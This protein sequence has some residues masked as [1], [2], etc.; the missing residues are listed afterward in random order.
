MTK[1]NKVT[2]N[3]SV[4][5]VDKFPRINTT[6]KYLIL[7]KYQN[8]FHKYYEE[9]LKEHMP[10]MLLKK[11]L[12]YNTSKKLHEALLSS[13]Y[14]DIEPKYIKVK[15]ALI[16]GDDTHF[17]N[18]SGWNDYFNYI[19]SDK[20]FPIFKGMP[21]RNRSHGGASPTDLPA[22]FIL[23]LIKKNI[24]LAPLYH[25]GLIYTNSYSL[26]KSVKTIFS[27]DDRYILIVKTIDS[28]FKKSVIQLYIPYL[29]LLSMTISTKDITNEDLDEI[30]NF[31]QKN[32]LII[33]RALYKEEQKKHT[34]SR[35]SN[36]LKQLSS[37][38]I[39]A[40]A[41]VTTHSRRI[42]K[43][44]TIDDYLKSLYSLYE[45]ENFKYN[46]LVDLAIRHFKK[47]Y[48]VEGSTKR[49]VQS[50]VGQLI[51]FL[52]LLHERFQ[53]ESITR[54]MMSTFL[55]YPESENT[56]QHI[57]RKREKEGKSHAYLTR[58]Q[59]VVIDFLNS[60]DEYYGCYKQN[61]RLKFKNT[62]STLFRESL[63][64][65][66][67]DTIVDILLHRPPYMKEIRKWG[68]KEVDWSSWWPHK[69]IPFL[70]LSILLHLHIPL[71]SAHILNLDRDN[72][73]ITDNND[74]IRGFY[75]NTDK[76]TSK[77]EKH[78]VPNIYSNTLNIYKNLITLNKEMF[79]NLQKVKYQYDDNSPWEEFYPLFPN[80]NGDDVLGKS[81]YEKYFRIVVFTAQLEL[82]KRGHDIQIAWI[83]DSEAFP[84]S[85]HAIETMSAKFWQ[86]K[87][88]LSFGLHSLRVTGATRLLKMGL[89]P[90]LITLFT[91]HKNI[92]TLINIYIKIP[93]DELVE[94]FFKIRDA[95]DTTTLEGLSKNHNNIPKTIIQY[96]PSDN[97][98]EILAELKKNNIFTLP[99]ITINAKLT[100]NVR[101]EISNGLEL[102]SKIHWTHWKSYSFGICGKPDGCPIGAEDRCSLC[103][104]LATGPLYL[105]GVIAKTEQLQNRIFTHSNMILKNRELGQQNENGTLRKQQ[106]LD[107]EELTGWYDVI[108]KIEDTINSG[109][110]DNTLANPENYPQVQKAVKNLIS[111]E[112]VSE[113]DGL[114]QIYEKAKT[115]RIY[116]PDIENAIFRLSNKI[117]KWCIDNKKTSEIQNF[118]DQP[119]KV[120]EWFLPNQSIEYKGNQSLLG[121]EKMKT[122]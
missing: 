39:K 1:P 15:E 71:R 116:N 68:S 33:G 2:K 59:G 92:S 105:H 104:Y 119:E 12:A 93:N 98:K 57:L 48:L 49:T 61:T 25:N 31:Y 35:T 109:L 83:K 90:Q 29:V 41:N 112:M 82:Y 32:N 13:N 43:E 94:S 81:I 3:D 96:I 4:I 18:F 76:D 72:F 88:K 44:Q 108:S 8:D 52:H 53:G 102:M 36:M 16:V 107:I 9:S 67:Y 6:G 47:I 120:I 86:H 5:F 122:F 37:F 74:N 106:A 73:L 11:N 70:P 23:R 56:Y 78:I 64:D 80:H 118:L 24:L 20:S 75:I 38:F 63:D 79:P 121:H 55:D 69:M 14:Q 58:L 65:E 117:T 54:E 111:Y 10:T 97:P 66:V 77:R 60:T 62:G 26:S 95:V 50:K 87:V 17:E 19:D 113:M 85:H 101:E 21:T 51:D 27:K 114:I 99:R 22:K 34:K 84:Y 110:N 100:K 91:G 30:T 103:P 89:P 7:T 46:D 42:I 45:Y 40:G 115:L 28:Y